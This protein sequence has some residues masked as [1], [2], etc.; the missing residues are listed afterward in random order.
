MRRLRVPALDPVLGLGL[1]SAPPATADLAL[2]DEEPFQ[3]RVDL[4]ALPARGHRDSAPSATS[5]SVRSP[6]RIY[7]LSV[8]TGDAAVAIESPGTPSP[9][10]G[11]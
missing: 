1:T 6:R 7:R 11:C 8:P 5:S 10:P 9:G 2:H 3:S 4:S